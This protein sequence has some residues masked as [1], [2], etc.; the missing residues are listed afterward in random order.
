MKGKSENGIFVQP[1]NCPNS[2]QNIVSLDTSHMYVFLVD[3]EMRSLI[4]ENI[5]RGFACYKN[6]NKIFAHQ[7]TSIVLSLRS[8]KHHDQF[9]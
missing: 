5:P 9:C 3:K 2:L 8:N 4:K 1:S 7:T 6:E